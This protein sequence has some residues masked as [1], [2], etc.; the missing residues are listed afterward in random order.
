MVD[1]LAIIGR[2]DS[3]LLT[4]HAGD[5]RWFV[6]RNVAIALGKAGRL[7]AIPVLRSLTKHQDARVRVEAIRALAAV[8]ADATLGDVV[9]AFH[10]PDR[11]VRQAA[12]SLLRACSSPEVVTRLTDVVRLGKI[13]ALE[14][15][16]LVEVIGERR[17]DAARMALED[18]ASRRGRSG[19][20]KAV[21]SAAKRQLARRAQ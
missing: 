20:P 8:D 10:D 17:D 12:V 16:R 1:V 6:V 7:A 11:R 2:S 3:R 18:I 13:S 14:A 9:A 4:P 21:R 5:H 15:E 19:A